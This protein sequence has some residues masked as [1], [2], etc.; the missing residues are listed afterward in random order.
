MKLRLRLWLFCTLFVLII[1]ASIV[2]L[3]RIFNEPVSAWHSDP[4]A[5]CAVVLTGG[6]GRVREGFS[7]LG[8]QLVRRLVVS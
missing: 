3:R 7:L 1:S 4:K 8:R 6:A 5:D 2:H